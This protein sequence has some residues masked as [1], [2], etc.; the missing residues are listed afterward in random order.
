MFRGTPVISAGFQAKTSKF[1]PSKLIGPWRRSEIIA[2]S[3]GIIL[4]LRNVT[5]PPST[6]NFNIH[7]S[8][9]LVRRNHL[10][11][12]S[13][14]EPDENSVRNKDHRRM[15][16]RPLTFVQTKCPPILSPQ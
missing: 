4:L 14:P 8:W 2:H 11:S 1:C 6:G 7:V 9:M 5:V 12:Y 3:I 16:F 15:L 13:K 10:A